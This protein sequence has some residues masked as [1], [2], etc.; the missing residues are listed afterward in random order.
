MGRLFLIF[1]FAYAGSVAAQQADSGRGEEKLIW[2]ADHVY[3]RNDYDTSSGFFQFYLRTLT[4]TKGEKK[5]WRIDVPERMRHYLASSMFVRN[6]LSDTA[7]K[8][9]PDVNHQKEF[10]RCSESILGRVIVVADESGLIVLDKKDGR[11][12]TDVP[13]TNS[14]ERFFVDSG[15]YVISRRRKLCSGTLPHG[16]AFIENCAA[17][18]FH[19]SGSHLI[20]LD[21]EHRPVAILDYRANDHLKKA[22]ATNMQAVLRW[23]KYALELQGRV[24]L[25]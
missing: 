12:I 2:S 10:L 8:Q 16:A 18:L 24:Y 20:I 11:V 3:Q 19:F 15:R 22:G 21:K 17:Y 13:Y 4:Y 14:T 5:M 23:K 7:R 6:V 1:F 25:N 9:P